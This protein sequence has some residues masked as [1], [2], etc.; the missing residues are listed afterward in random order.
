MAAWLESNWGIASSFSRKVA[1]LYYW[2]WRQNLNPRI[3]SGYRDSSKQADLRAS[4][5]AGNRNGIIVR[6]AADSLHTRTNWYGGASSQ[7]IDIQTSNNSYAGSIA[8]W[9]NIG[10]GGDFR[11]A[12]PVHF[13]E[14][15]G[16]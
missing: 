11:Y 4:Y 16:V 8:K 6:P 15:K 7:A 9:L 2:L 13:Y 10:W 1:E 5:D 3:T 12:D 14:L